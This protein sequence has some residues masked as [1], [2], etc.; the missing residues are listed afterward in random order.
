MPVTLDK[1]LIAR[2]DVVIAVAEV[3]AAGPGLFRKHAWTAFRDVWFR[4]APILC[5][6]D[7]AEELVDD[8]ESFLKHGSFTGFSASTALLFA[9]IDGWIDGQAE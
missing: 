3:K 6:T 9:Y 4:S 5:V 8:V 2:N 7:R 1:F